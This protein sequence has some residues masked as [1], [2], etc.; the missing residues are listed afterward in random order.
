MKKILEEWKKFVNEVEDTSLQEGDELAPDLMKVLRNMVRQ[1]Y[2]DEI[3]QLSD[4]ADALEAR[5]IKADYDPMRGRDPLRVSHD[6]KMFAIQTRDK[7]FEPEAVVGRFGVDR[8]S[9][10]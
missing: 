6:G 10:R 3:R 5:G 4:L 8:I 9:Q 2:R 7:V 1:G